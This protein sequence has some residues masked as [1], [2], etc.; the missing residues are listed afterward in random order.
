MERHVIPDCRVTV[1]IKGLISLKIM[2]MNKIHDANS[3]YDANMLDDHLIKYR[4]HVCDSDISIIY[5]L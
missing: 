1:Q 4:V 2:Q 3:K 5:L